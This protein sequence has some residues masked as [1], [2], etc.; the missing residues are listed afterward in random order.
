MQ[1]HLFI[2]ILSI[3]HR[4]NILQYRLERKTWVKL[5]EDRWPKDQ[6]RSTSN[7]IVTIRPSKSMT[8]TMILYISTQLKRFKPKSEITMHTSKIS[9]HKYFPKKLKSDHLSYLIKVISS[10]LFMIA[11]VSQ[12]SSGLLILIL[13]N[14][15]LIFYFFALI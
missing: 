11:E 5:S 15:H 9:I 8:K 2:L 7:G 4:V 14:F 12:F 1:A 3:K 6:S 10:S 13:L